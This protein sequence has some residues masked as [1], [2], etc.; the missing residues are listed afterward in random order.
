MVLRLLWL[1]LCIPAALSFISPS[2]IRGPSSTARNVN[3]VDVSDLGLTVDD[4]NAPLP[5]DVLQGIASS[6]YQTTSK[7]P[8]INDN[9]CQWA[10]N[11]DTME[12]TLKIPGLRGQPAACLAVEFSTTTATITAFG[13]VVWSCILRGIAKPET[14][15]F[16][17]EDGDDMIPVVQ[18]S[19]EKEDAATRWGGFILQIGEDSLL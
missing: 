9:G 2:V 8:D 15:W 3:E 18:I 5:Q 17:T 12:A 13:R 14:G 19:V 10:E 7:V 16:L 11:G 4:L 6:G 1:G